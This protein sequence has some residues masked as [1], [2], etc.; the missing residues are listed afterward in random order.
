MKE[1]IFIIKKEIMPIIIK[2]TEQGNDVRIDATCQVNL[3]SLILGT[4]YNSSFNSYYK[5]DPKNSLISLKTS[6]YLKYFDSV[7]S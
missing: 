1:L 7:S 2:I 5:F 3:N 6:F 4:Y